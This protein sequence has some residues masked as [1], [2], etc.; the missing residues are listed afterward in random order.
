MIEFEKPTQQLNFKD[1]WTGICKVQN[2]G[3]TLGKKY[4]VTE[5]TNTTSSLRPVKVVSDGGKV[6]TVH[7]MRFEEDHTIY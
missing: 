6:V 5:V 4:E 3:L 1:K 7:A 2:E